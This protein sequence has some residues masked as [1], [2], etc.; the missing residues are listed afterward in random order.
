MGEGGSVVHSFI[1][2]AFRPEHYSLARR[3]M[4]IDGRSHI[5]YPFWIVVRFLP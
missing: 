1:E 5:F 2:R 3:E 4:V